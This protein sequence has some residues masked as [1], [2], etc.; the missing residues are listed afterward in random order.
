M[1]VSASLDTDHIQLS[2]R[3][4]GIGISAAGKEKL[5]QPFQR[6]ETVPG[7]ALQGVRSGLVVCRRLVEAHGGGFGWSQSRAR[8]L[9]SS[10]RCRHNPPFQIRSTKHEIRNKFEYQM[11]KTFWSF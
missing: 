2:V 8:G 4:Q 7:T 1:K 3:D 5:F 10:S 9:R 6:L 11:V